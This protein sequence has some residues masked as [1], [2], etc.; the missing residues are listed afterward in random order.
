MKPNQE[1]MADLLAVST[2]AAYDL[3]MRALGFGRSERSLRLTA[4]ASHQG[5]V[6]V[7]VPSAARAEKTRE[8]LQELGAK[9]ANVE[10]VAPDPAQ[11]P[12]KGRHS[13][14]MFHD[15]DAFNP[16]HLPRGFRG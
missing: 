14:R 12:L 4:A 2:P 8:A 16:Q 3:N 1:H 9:M 7:M 6:V 15:P 11:N 13:S 5:R 10:I